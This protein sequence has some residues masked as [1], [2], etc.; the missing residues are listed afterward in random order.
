MAEGPIAGLVAV[1]SIMLSRETRR[2]ADRPW[3]SCC[4]SVWIPKFGRL[5][6]CQRIRLVLPFVTD[7]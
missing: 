5:P 6:N 3:D 1:P 4:S 7:L 2:M